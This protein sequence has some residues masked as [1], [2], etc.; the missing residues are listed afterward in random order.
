M[1]IIFFILVFVLIIPTSIQAQSIRERLD[2]IE[3]Q[4][5]MLEQ[6]RLLESIQKRQQENNN[7]ARPIDDFFSKKFSANLKKAVQIGVPKTN[8]ISDPASWVRVVYPKGNTAY[9]FWV[10]KP[11]IVNLSSGEV[12]YWF[13]FTSTNVPINK[14]LGWD[15]YIYSQVVKKVRNCLNRDTKLLAFVEYTDKFGLGNIFDVNT[16]ILNDKEDW[17]LEEKKILC[18]SSMIDSLKKKFGY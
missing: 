7:A 9:Q 14:A 3:D 10:Y 4:L 12:T 13:M 6:F 11:S 15:I 18:S 8:P 2:D 17:T 5:I 16:N 1:K